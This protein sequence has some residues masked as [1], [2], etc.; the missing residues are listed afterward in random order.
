MTSVTLPSILPHQLAL[1]V[2]TMR[3]SGTHCLSMKGPVPMALRLAKVSCDTLRR[4]LGSTELFFS[5]QALLIMR[6]SVIWLSSTGLGPLV[7]M[8]MV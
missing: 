3:W 2:K 8:S 1:R 4:S 6:S 5:A 7:K